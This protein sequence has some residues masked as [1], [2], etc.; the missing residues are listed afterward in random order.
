MQCLGSGNQIYLPAGLTAHSEK[1]AFLKVTYDFTDVD[2]QLMC[3]VMLDAPKRWIR[4]PIERPSRKRW[5]T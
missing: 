2:G 5:A 3:G 4:H 1:I